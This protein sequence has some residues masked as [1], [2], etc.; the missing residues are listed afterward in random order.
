MSVFNAAKEIINHDLPIRPWAQQ[1]ENPAKITDDS[2]KDL[3]VI[4]TEDIKV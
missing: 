1:A 3:G 2:T 4:A